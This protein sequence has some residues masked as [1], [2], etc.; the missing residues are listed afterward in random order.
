M[1]AA[2][3]REVKSSSD[4]KEGVKRSSSSKKSGSRQ[5][6]SSKR[7]AKQDRTSGKSGSRRHEAGKPTENRSSKAKDKAHRR[8]RR[9]RAESNGSGEQ[10]LGSS[11]NWE[12]HQRE[13]AERRWVQQTE[14]APAPHSEF[15]AEL[16]SALAAG[17]GATPVAV[18]P[19]VAPVAAAIAEAASG[20][21]RSQPTA[22]H[23]IDA[24]H[25]ASLFDE[26]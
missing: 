19:P 4:G 13:I 20:D 6:E 15:A 8:S 12:A 26:L 7:E 5:R 9:K 24:D 14:A 11:Q 17:D 3:R 1:E 18:V 10:T 25:L 16:F 23:R 2:K 22:Q 21:S